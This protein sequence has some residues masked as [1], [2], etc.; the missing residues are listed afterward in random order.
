MTQNFSD[1][2][3]E[4]NDKKKIYLCRYLAE[5]GADYTL[6]LIHGTA[7][8]GGC[9][10]DFAAHLC[11]QGVNVYTFDL[12]GHGRSSGQRGVFT[13]EEFL[14]DTRVVT[15]LAAK[16]TGLPVVVH[17]A[18]QGG[19]IAFHAL[20]YCDSVVG[21]ICM[22]ILLSNELPLNRGV[23]FLRSDFAKLLGRCFG[24][25]LKLPLLKLINFEAAYQ[26]DP[27]LL[28]A[29]KKDPLYVW[30]YGLKSYLSIFN[31]TPKILPKANKKPILITVGENDE[32]VS[33]AHCRRCFEAIGGPKNFFSFPAGG[34]QLM[35]F[36]KIT[37][38]RIVDSWIRKNI[39]AKESD[40]TPQFT[41]GE[42]RYFSFLKKQTMLDSEGEADY[43]YSLMDRLLIKI[44][45]GAISRGV[46]YF[47]NVDCSDQW[48]FTEKLVSKI[49][50][51]AW[52]FLS[53][54]VPA[55]GEKNLAVLGCGG[56]EAIAGLL[57][58]HP[59]FKEW[60]IVGVDVD[61][62]A[63]ERAK[64]R[65]AGQDSIR[66]IIGDAENSDVVCADSYELIHMHGIFDHCGDHRALLTNLYRGLK[67]GGRLFYVTP[68]RNIATW[69]TFVFFGPLYVFKMYKS[70]HDFRRFPRPE[71]LNRMFVDI[72][73]KLVQKHG[74]EEL[75]VM[76]LDYK[77]INPFFIT[78]AVSGRKLD[79]IEYIHSGPNKWLKG[80][81]G[82][83]VGVVEKS[84]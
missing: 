4:V 18:S 59:E 39:L 64:Q 79:E 31:Y 69:L 55:G 53:D 10:H 16:E 43:Q 67:P 25:R 57:E 81:L 33:E 80:Y 3:I 63:V 68:D 5:F 30:K 27:G 78:K 50:Y 22:N 29:K 74:S 72:G 23:R 17:G 26:E 47:S 12:S 35:M 56:G 6:V 19:E 62:N 34:H 21:G 1:D 52:D 2:F 38:A 11:A 8:H 65:F 41:D 71:E 9:Y 76:G 66:F 40:W 51:C 49:D 70:I 14:E 37:Y 36:E 44:S 46:S 54:Y 73:Y 84:A 48:D 15:D 28:G 32:V 7:G 60:N 13:F 45:N 82:E 24:D 58:R 83:Y 61:F 75:A 42:L 20:D 77:R